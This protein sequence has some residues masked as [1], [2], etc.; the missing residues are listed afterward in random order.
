MGRQKFS[1]LSVCITWRIAGKLAQNMTVGWRK[2][3]QPF[4]LKFRIS[5]NIYTSFRYTFTQLKK[6]TQ[7][8]CSL[9]RSTESHLVL[10][11][12]QLLGG[13]TGHQSALWIY[14]RSIIF[15]VNAHIIQLEGRPWQFFTCT[16]LSNGQKYNF[17]NTPPLLYFLLCD[18]TISEMQFDYR[19]RGVE[20]FLT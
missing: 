19:F 11:R 3:N 2:W 20:D 16:E 18:H 8:F 1:L 9:W 5:S 14:K 12:W 4:Y 15:L 17:W 13:Q 6:K 10:K 7:K